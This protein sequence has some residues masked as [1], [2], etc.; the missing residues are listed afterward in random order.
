MSNSIILKGKLIFKSKLKVITGLHI[1]G[2]QSGLEIGGIDSIVVRDPLTNYPYVPGSSIKGKMRSLLE[3]KL[4]LPLNR[5][6]RTARNEVRI[7]ECKNKENYYTCKVC[8]LFGIAGESGLATP[9]RL[10]VRDVFLSKESAKALE[11][12]ETGYPFTEIKWEASI[13]RITSAAVPRQLERVPAGTVFEPLVMVVNIFEGGDFT[14][15]EDVKLLISLF[16]AMELLEDDYLGGMGSRGYGQIKFEELKLILK[17]AAHYKD[18]Q[19]E[20]PQKIIEEK[21]V[22]S[23]RKKENEII[24]KIISFFEVT[25]ESTSNRSYS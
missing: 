7:H 18:P 11:K 6:M 4:G 14:F 22:S 16:E 17:T 3:R 20:P 12:L 8:K 15:T 10:Y 23:I 19:K 2:A 1:G 13:D 21:E 24:E 5:T 9:T 25:N